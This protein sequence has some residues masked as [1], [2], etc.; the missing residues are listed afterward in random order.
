MI[1]VSIWRKTLVRLE[2]CED[3][4]ALFDAIASQQPASDPLRMRRI[5]VARW[6]HLH[7]VWAWVAAAGFARW[8]E[9]R[10]LIPR[11]DLR[12]AYLSGA[13]LSGAN[14]SGADLSGAYLT[15]ANLSG[16]DLTGAYLTD[17]YLRGANLTDADLSGAYLRGAYLRGADLRYAYRGTSPVIPG[18][19]TNAAGYLERAV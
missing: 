8:L 16:A 13:N 19:R 7:S 4:L 9:S 3:G 2:A 1:T 12:G 17:A 5:R 11:A 18:W 6:T 15:G 14:L 10:S